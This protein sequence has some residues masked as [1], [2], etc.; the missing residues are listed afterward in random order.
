M[1]KQN[2]DSVVSGAK[3]TNHPLSSLALLPFNSVQLRENSYAAI[4]AG[5]STSYADAPA[6]QYDGSLWLWLCRSVI[7]LG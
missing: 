3:S 1:L 4:W 6:R 2:M 7:A 5:Y